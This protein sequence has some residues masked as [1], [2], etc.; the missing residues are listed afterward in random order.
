MFCFLWFRGDVSRRLRWQ[1]PRPAHLH[2]WHFERQSKEVVAVLAH[3]PVI[4]A[5][6]DA[7]IESLG[8]CALDE[9]DIA[10]LSSFGYLR[11][12]VVQQ[13][14]LAD[15]RLGNSVGGV[16]AEVHVAS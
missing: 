10:R 14:R 5:C 3:A 2:E 11:M 8:I 7:D 12:P 6:S 15:S 1:R 13:V 16:F 4:V 9:C